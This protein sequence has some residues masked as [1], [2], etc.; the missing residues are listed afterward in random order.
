MKRFLLKIFLLTLPLF[1]ILVFVNYFGDAANL[2]KS[3]YESRMADIMISGSFVSNISNYDERT[4]QKKLIQKFDEPPEIV[5]IGSSRTMLINQQMY[6][7]KKLFNNSVSG[8]NLKDLIAIYQLYK[9]NN[10]TPKKIIF[11]LDPWMFNNNESGNRWKSLA[12][13]YNSFYAK[14]ETSSFLE[15]GAMYKW[16]QL[17]SFSYFQIS[18]RR[19]DDKI[20]SKSM[21]IATNSIYNST[22]TKLL[23]GS[24]VYGDAYRTASLDEVEVKISK[25]IEGDIY[26]MNG[27]NSFFTEKIEVLDKLCSDAIK[28]NIEVEFFLS[29][30]PLKSFQALIEK[31]PTLKKLEDEIKKYAESKNIKVIGSFNPNKFELDNSFFYDGMH[32]KKEAI[33]KLITAE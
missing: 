4:F 28:N 14:N 7:Q 24:L 6:P 15:N 31:Y 18:M 9:D 8:A 19:L 13:Q 11:G 12:K 3:E 30:Y 33:L 22:N 27:F 1:L 17:L 26:G 10:L 29:P 32:C 20:K 5:I 21:P 25:Y 16:S 23:D 2:F